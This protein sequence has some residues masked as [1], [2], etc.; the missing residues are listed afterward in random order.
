MAAI[1]LLF[2]EMTLMITRGTPCSGGIPLPAQ[3]EVIPLRLPAGR[4][5]RRKLSVLANLPYYLGSMIGHVRRADVVHTP[6]PGDIPLLGMLVALAFRKRLIARYGGSWAANSQTTVMGRVTKAIMCKYAGGRNV[7]LATGEGETVPARDMQWIFVSS[8]SQA[9][10]RQIH[11]RLDKGLSV[12]PRL[13]Y[14]GRLSPE[15]GVLV[16]IKALAKLKDEDFFRLPHV[17]LAGDGPQRPELEQAVA[18]YGC[19]DIIEFAGQLDRNSLSRE[20]LAADICVQPSL[21]EGFSKAW[22]DA[23]SHGVPVVASDVGAARAVIGMEGERGWIMPP[24]DVERLA[25]IL[26]RILSDSIDWCALRRRC[27]AYVEQ[28]TLE[29]WARRIGE[30]CAAQW[31]LS[32]KAKSQ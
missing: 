16:L 9:E 12:P 18:K 19:T 21:T 14:A 15:K 11:P 32:L 1:G 28:R 6:L 27:R 26:R 7:M 24:G 30:I 23:M 25:A 29:D 31:K 2:D 17:I 22:L 20:F 3:A 8:L 10:L 5:L 4:D 13:I